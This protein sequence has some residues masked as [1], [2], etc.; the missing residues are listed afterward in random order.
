MHIREAA[1]DAVVSEDE[2]GV[3]DPEEMQDRR[4]KVIDFRRVLA[5]ARLV[6]PLVAFPG[7]DAALDASA[8][9]PVGEDIGIVIAP[10]PALRAWHAPKLRG[11]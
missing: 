9:Q 5:V 1:I 4:V 8:R 10:L 2:L 3:V 11:P 7:D 6:A